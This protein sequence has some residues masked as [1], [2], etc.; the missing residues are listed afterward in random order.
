MTGAEAILMYFLGFLTGALAYQ[1]Y[2]RVRR[3]SIY[4][5]GYE[6]GFFEGRMAQLIDLGHRMGCD[7]PVN[8]KEEKTDD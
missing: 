5:E 2:I 1:L 4:E 7:K 6:T 3:K 8:D